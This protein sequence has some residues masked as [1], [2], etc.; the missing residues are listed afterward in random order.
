MRLLGV[1]FLSPKYS[2]CILDCSDFV[3]WLLPDVKTLLYALNATV[4]CNSFIRVPLPRNS[5]FLFSLVDMVVDVLIV[6]ELT[7]NLLKNKGLWCL[8][9]ISRVGHFYVSC[10][11]SNVKMIMFT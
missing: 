6:G 3:D 5:I 4:L 2:S 1:L 9:V 7:I 8:Y 11:R 10:F